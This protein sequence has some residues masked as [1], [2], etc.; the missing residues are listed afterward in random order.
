MCFNFLKAAHLAST[1][2]V[3]TEVLKRI[4]TLNVLK[5]DIDATTATNQAIHFR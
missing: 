1:G 5:H 3:A 4:K 2:E